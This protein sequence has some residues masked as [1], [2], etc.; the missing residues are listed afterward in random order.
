MPNLNK[1]CCRTKFTY[2][3]EVL[4]SDD[5]AQHEKL[6]AEMFNNYE[7]KKSTQVLHRNKEICFKAMFVHR[8]DTEQSLIVAES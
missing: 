3:F 8:Q 5:E 2:F 4:I 7:I 1:F 6:F